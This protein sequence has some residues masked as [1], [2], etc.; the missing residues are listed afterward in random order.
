MEKKRK[1]NIAGIYRRE[2][3]PLPWLQAGCTGQTQKPII[4]AQQVMLRHPT[5][6]VK[7]R[8]KNN[9]NPTDSV[10]ER[11]KNNNNPTD[12]VKER[13][14]NNNNQCL[15]TLVPWYLFHILPLI[16]LQL[17]HNPYRSTLVPW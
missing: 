8:T 17:C 7:E 1:R 2:I 5:D 9:N 12:R 3:G 16:P 15:S 6:S 13:T 10:K 4:S 14:K 11:T